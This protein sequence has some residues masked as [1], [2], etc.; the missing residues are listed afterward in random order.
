MLNALNCKADDTYSRIYFSQINFVKIWTFV[1]C[2]T[3]NEHKN[4]ILKKVIVRIQSLQTISL[5][6]KIKSSRNKSGKSNPLI[7]NKE[8]VFISLS[9]AEM[10]SPISVHI[11]SK[12]IL[13]KKTVII[14]FD[15][16]LKASL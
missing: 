14:L 7:N 4:S 10:K 16:I 6:I 8:I 5:R 15:V 12:N 9:I 11:H 3:S 1:L 2:Q 13:K